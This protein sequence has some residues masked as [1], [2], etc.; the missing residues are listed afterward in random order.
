INTAG[1]L[2][3]ETTAA[4]T[5]NS[6]TTIVELVEQA[7]AEKGERARLADRIARPLVPGALVLAA[8]V[9]LVGSLLGDRGRLRRRA[10]GGLGAAWPWALARS[11][12]VSVVA[13]SGSAGRF[14]VI[15]R[16]G[17][18]CGRCG[19]IRHVAVDKTG[20]L[21]RNEPAVTAV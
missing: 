17:A 7:Q 10:R 19:T 3:V 12:R 2:E 14:G 4:G 15:I 16:S 6:L 20:T 13:A 9:A 11:G 8:L 5:D 21:T 18:V 1:V